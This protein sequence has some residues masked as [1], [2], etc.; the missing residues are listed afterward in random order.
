[1][2]KFFFNDSPNQTKVALLLEE[3]GLPYDP[4]PI[5]RLPAACARGH[6]L[7]N[8]T[9]RLTAARQMWP[10]HFNRRGA[11]QMNLYRALDAICAMAD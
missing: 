8:G 11:T 6:H 10:N 4:I 5:D 9:E 3:L 2:L 1:M 7:A